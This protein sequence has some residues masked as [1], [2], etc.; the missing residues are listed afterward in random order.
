MKLMKTSMILIAAMTLAGCQSAYR[1][2][3]KE[4]ANSFKNGDYQTHTHSCKG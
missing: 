4:V 2:H 1:N 3:A